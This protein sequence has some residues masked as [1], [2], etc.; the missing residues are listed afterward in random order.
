MIH[1][2]TRALIAQ[3]A[4]VVLWE[5][6]ELSWKLWDQQLVIYDTVRALPLTA[7]TVVLL[8]ARQFGKSVLVVAMALEDCLRNP[9]VIVLIIA[10]SIKHARSIV[11]PRIKMLMA[12]CPK[13]LIKCLKSED[14]WYFANGSELRLGGFETK[15][16]SERGKTV[17][18]IYMEETREADGDSYVEYLRSDIGPALTHSE[19]AQI[20]HATTMP[21]IP[22][23]PFVLETI[24]EAEEAGAYF[25]FTIHDNR[26]LSKRKYDACVKLCG[27]E[28]TTAFRV[29][30]LCEMVRDAS[31]ILAPEFDEPIHVK[32]VQAPTYT[33]FWIGGDVGGVRDASVFLLCCYDF[34]R[35]KILFLDERY[36]GPETGSAEMVAAV[37]AME[38]SRKIVRFVDAPGQLQIDFMGQHKFACAL[39]KKEGLE[40]SINLV[41]VALQTAAIEISPKCRLLITTLR[42]GTFNANRT[43][44]ARTSTL[45]HMDAIMAAVYAI[46]HVNK[47][48]PYPAYGGASPYTH[49]IRPSVQNATLAGLSSMLGRGVKG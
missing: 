35:A 7:Q 23:H 43:D 15:A 33:N 11:I 2:E 28:T 18:K 16:A 27:G 41:R 47:S 21:K 39:P 32:E 14:T 25:K 13:G 17:Y 5:R 48:N 12:D 19:H 40:A 10:P 49:Y 24:P 4:K 37:K 26:K 6:G 1:V 22:D 8:C 9:N 36:F 42:S 45:W 31:V 20:V 46:R 44:L 30:Y 29:E 3:T 34:E 38:G